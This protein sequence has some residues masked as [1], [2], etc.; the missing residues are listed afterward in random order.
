MENSNLKEI[1]KEFLKAKNVLLYPHVGI[2]GDALGSSIAVTIALRKLGKNCFILY[3]EEMPNNLEFMLKSDVPYITDNMDIISDENLDISC[4]IDNGAYQRFEHFKEK[5]NKAKLTVCLDHHSTS[6]GIAKLNY[7]RPD[8]S[9]CGEIIFSFLKELDE[10]SGNKILPDIEIANAIFAAI[11]TDTGNFQFS[12]T[13]KEAHLI[14]A[15]MM[16]WGFKENP[17]SNEIYEN[18][19]LSKIKAENLAISRMEILANGKVALSYISKE[20]LDE[21]G[22]KAGETDPI[23]KTLRSISGV[24]YAA[25]LKEKEVGEVRVSYRAK[26]DGND[27]SGIAKSHNGGG[28]KKAAGATLN[29]SLKEAYDITKRDLVDLANEGR[30][31]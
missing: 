27:I 24:E 16:D 6:E 25:F 2:D 21:L 31:N 3:D 26:T 4:A 19:T 13:T 11:T 7:I 8:R 22:V 12:N 15:E 5:F 10:L 20:E 18:Q 28:H 29:T 30:N 1:A 9:A 14:I 23:V 17:I